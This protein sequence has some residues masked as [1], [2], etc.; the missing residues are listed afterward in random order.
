MGWGQASQGCHR[1]TPVKPDPNPCQH[2][3][4]GRDSSNVFEVLA[5][6]LKHDNRCAIWSIS[7]I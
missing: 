6:G 5:I 1:D 7:A 4:L 3:Y 2:V